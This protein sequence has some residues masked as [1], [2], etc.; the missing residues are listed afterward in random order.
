M[1]G[2]ERDAL[3]GKSRGSHAGRRNA[4]N[5]QR[6]VDRR[7]VFSLGLLIASKSSALLYCGLKKMP[8]LRIDVGGNWRSISSIFSEDFSEPFGVAK[9]IAAA[10]LHPPT[11]PAF[12]V[13]LWPAL[14]RFESEKLKRRR[15]RA[16]VHSWAA[17]CKKILV[18][19]DDVGL[20]RVIR[21]SA[22]VIL[23][24]EWILLEP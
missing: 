3:S 4:A 12:A 20:L 24:C 2:G 5:G 10:A 9:R 8:Q 14:P 18:V 22:H 16:S 13:K 23:H 21:G 15:F 7:V 17:A 1:A 19:D 11:S 6:A